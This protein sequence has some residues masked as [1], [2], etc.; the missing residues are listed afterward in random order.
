LHQLLDLAEFMEHDDKPLPVTS[1]A[2]LWP[3][4]ALGSVERALRRST[5]ARLVRWRNDVTRTP[6]RCTTKRCVSITLR[7][8]LRIDKLCV[9][10]CC[11]QIEFAS[12]PASTIEALISIYNELQQPGL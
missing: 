12:T 2:R 8:L 1:I 3:L 9:V 7:E 6:K 5:F 4:G 11:W 10:R